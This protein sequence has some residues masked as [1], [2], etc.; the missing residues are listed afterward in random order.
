MDVA[1]HGERGN[2]MTKI[3]TPVA[4]QLPDDFDARLEAFADD[5]TMPRWLGVAQ[6]CADAIEA[7]GGKS[8]KMIVYHAAAD[9]FNLGLSTIRL[10]ARYNSELGDFFSEMTH[11][12]EWTQVRCA[13][14]ESRQRETSVEAVLLE[15]YAESD[16]WGGKLCPA[17]VWAAQLKGKPDE[18]NPVIVKLERLA[19]CA[20]TALKAV[21][22]GN[23]YSEFAARLHELS[24][25]ADAILADAEAK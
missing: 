9:K 7:M 8:N 23:G 19:S 10:W 17:R 25:T 18:R 6:V 11:V 21:S 1:Y 4:T 13:W 14:Q 24:D 16:K 3:A 15:R 2:G 5:A 12:P 22:S 20:A